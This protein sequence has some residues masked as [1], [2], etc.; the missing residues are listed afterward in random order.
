MTKS[1]F[2]ICYKSRE[3]NYVVALLLPD[4][5]PPFNWQKKIGALQFRYQYPIMPKGL[6]S[7]LIV[8]V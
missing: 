3:G 8:R 7:R 4:T 2:D 6:I 1:N 5:A